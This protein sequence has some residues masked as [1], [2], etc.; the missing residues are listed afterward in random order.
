MSINNDIINNNNNIISNNSNKIFKNSLINSINENK[1]YIYLC[2]YCNKD[3]PEIISLEG[4]QE[5]INE[6]TIDKISIICSYGNNELNLIDYL[7]LLEQNN[8]CQNLNEYCYNQNQNHEAIKASNYCSKCNKWFCDK[9][10]IYHKS[11]LSDHFTTP[12]T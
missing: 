8:K 5:D 4:I 6:Q 1:N 7:N 3:T 11:L 10:L 2:P 12:K 9:C